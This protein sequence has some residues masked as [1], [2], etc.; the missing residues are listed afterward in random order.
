MRDRLGGKGAGLGTLAVEKGGGRMTLAVRVLTAACSV[1]A[2]SLAHLSPADAETMKWRER[3]RNT[4]VHS[5]PVGDAKDHVIGLGQQRGI[6]LFGGG[7]GA[8]ILVKFTFDGTGETTT[9]QGYGLYVFK[10]G[11]RFYLR[12]QGGGSTPT[13]HEGTLS[14]LRGTG[15]FKGVEGSGTWTAAPVPPL[16]FGTRKA[17]SV[18]A[19]VRCPPADSCPASFPALGDP[20][21]PPMEGALAWAGPR[22]RSR[23]GL[24]PGAL[25]LVL[26]DMPSRADPDAEESTRVGIHGVDQ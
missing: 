24:L 6:A 17:V 15:R 5:V 22:G 4:Q 12:F 3:F 11:S 20:D 2:W 1:G 13:E 10:D 25:G 7:E 21:P 16:S 8:R 23:L 26:D 14:L 18:T 9:Y 19:N